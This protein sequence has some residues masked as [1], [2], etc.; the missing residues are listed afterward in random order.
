MPCCKCP[1]VLEGND[2]DPVGPRKDG[3]VS[4]QNKC[5]AYFGKMMVDPESMGKMLNVLQ[6]LIWM[7]KNPVYFGE[8]QNFLNALD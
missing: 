1:V 2:K 8:T 6:I 5:T 4:V 7:R 3:D